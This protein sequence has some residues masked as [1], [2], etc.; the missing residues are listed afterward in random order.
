MLL[1]I[2][3]VSN[4]I[5]NSSSEVF[6]IRD[7]GQLHLDSPESVKAF[8]MGE[9]SWAADCLLEDM[10]LSF[11]E[12]EERELEKYDSRGELYDAYKDKY[13]GV[14]L[15]QYFLEI[16][17]SDYSDY[18]DF[19]DACSSARSECINYVSCR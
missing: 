3:S 15:G 2:Q 6:L 12:L 13:E 1:P 4:L 17:D 5:T 11:Y 9:F 16:S 10:G 8:V 14:L 19:E 7:W 18:E